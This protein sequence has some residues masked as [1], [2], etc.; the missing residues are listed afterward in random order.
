ML[1]TYSQEVKIRSSYK[2]TVIVSLVI[3]VMLY[4]GYQFL[5]TVFIFTGSI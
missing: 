5:K 3:G 1:K 4:G 2:E